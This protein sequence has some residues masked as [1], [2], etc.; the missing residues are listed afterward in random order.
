[1]AQPEDVARATRAR[2]CQLHPL[3]PRVPEASSSGQMASPSAPEPSLV[4][5]PRYRDLRPTPPDQTTQPAHGEAMPSTSGPQ[6]APYP[7]SSFPPMHSSATRQAR[8]WL[9]LS[10][11]TE[12]LI[13]E[14]NA[15]R[16]Q[17]LLDWIAG[18]GHATR[19]WPLYL[20]AQA[21][22]LKQVEHLERFDRQAA[23][24]HA[25]SN[26]RVEDRISQWV[27]SGSGGHASEA[28]IFLARR[29]GPS[30]DG[31]GTGYFPA[32]V[33]VHTITGVSVIDDAG[34][35][36]PLLDAYYQSESVP[37]AAFNNVVPLDP[38][39]TPGDFEI[40]MRA[41]SENPKWVYISVRSRADCRY[42]LGS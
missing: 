1:M 24:A 22:T 17:R 38:E 11:E 5:L 15:R 14:F 10:P 13:S 16:Q 7:H 2:G 21:I 25:I 42:G 29:G 40:C 34:I 8:A 35:P 19:P 30:D 20:Q 23:M 9:T 36:C 26:R 28:R 39:G 3:R 31:L 6:L 33:Y 12:N 32:T 41:V 27:S 18:S 4:A 37:G